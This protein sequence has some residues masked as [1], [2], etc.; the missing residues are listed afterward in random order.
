MIFNI[1]ARLSR[2]LLLKERISSSASKFFPLRV[3]ASFEGFQNPR[4]QT[5]AIKINCLPL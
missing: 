4:M 2:G 1:A 5:E 3:D